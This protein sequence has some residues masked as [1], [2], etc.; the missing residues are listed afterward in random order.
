[1]DSMIRHIHALLHPRRVSAQRLKT[2]SR[3]SGRNSSGVSKKAAYSRIRLKG[4]RG[5]PLTASILCL[6]SIPESRREKMT[7]RN[8]MDRIV[9]PTPP[10]S[11]FNPASYRVEEPVRAMVE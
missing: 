5:R 6:E 8:G 4:K 7:I 10:P 9:S 11:D 3:G 1:M 2:V